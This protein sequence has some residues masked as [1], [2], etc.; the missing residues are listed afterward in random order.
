MKNSKWIDK[1]FEE[2]KYR[3]LIL[4]YGNIYD[5][6]YYEGE[7][8]TS[9]DEIINEN[10]NLNVIKSFFTEKDMEKISNA[11]IEEKLDE[12]YSGYNRSDALLEV[13][14]LIE[15]A[16]VEMEGKKIIY[17]KNTHL[18]FNDFN[19][20][21]DC[22]IS[23]SIHYFNEFLQNTEED[24]CVVMISD[25][26]NY[27]PKAIY[28]NNSEASVIHIEKPEED[29]RK[30]FIKEYLPETIVNYN[31]TLMKFSQST[32]GR[33]LKEIEMI[34][35]KGE[36]LS[37]DY[38]DPVKFISYYDFE[39][40]ESPWTKLDL[41]ELKEIDKKL[42]ERVLGQDHAVM[43]IKK[44][45][46]RAKLNLN[47]VHQ[48]EESN[49]PIGIFFFVG[50]TGVGKTELAK[51]MTDAIFGNEREFK[52]FD[53]S[54]YKE[55]VSLNKFIGA[56]PGYVGYE[57]GGQLTNWV[58]EHPFSVILFD[59]IEKANPKI[60]DNFLQILEDGRL[61]DN[62]GKTVYFKESILI[63]TS[64]IGNKKVNK[65]I[66]EMENI[67]NEKTRELYFSEVKNYFTDELGRV[68]ILNRIG[69]NIIPFNHIDSEEIYTKIISSKLNII[70]KNIEKNLGC[71]IEI[72]KEIIGF[73]IK[74]IKDNKEKFGGRAVVNFLESY[75]INEF[76]IFYIEK[77]VKKCK[78]VVNGKKKSIEFIEN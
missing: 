6:F 38:N 27:F 60:W 47:S 31:K 11:I 30:E 20:N 40:K 19:F 55:E 17:I 56:S 42:K 49:K 63:F 72:G 45:L 67:N 7:L 68:E 74:R 1:F 73:I 14:Q 9:I 59:E 2:I 24:I 25:K 12:V 36:D 10:K 75:F 71:T 22:Q 23:H 58:S 44:I 51:A 33:T 69:N 61:T 65:N 32:H 39:E 57:E 50:P 62:K 29:I 35:I 43:F 48:E 53:M 15:K 28:M 13:N 41:K 34:F 37:L 76:G 18:F 66:S 64:N 70:I 5:H 78:A 77:E 8:I 4:L 46:V 52:R 3:K 54:E 21:S 16:K 26:L